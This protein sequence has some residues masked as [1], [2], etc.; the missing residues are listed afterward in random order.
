MTVRFGDISSGS[1]FSASSVGGNGSSFSFTWEHPVAWTQLRKYFEKTMGDEESKKLISI[2]ESNAKSL[3]D[4]LDVAYLKADGGSVFGE[5]NFTGNVNFTGYVN[6]PPPG[7]VVQWAGASTFTAPDGWLFADGSEWPI[8]QLTNL[9]NALTDN[10]TVFPYGANTNGSGG[11]GSTHFRLPN[12]AGRVPVGIDAGQ[13]EFDTMGETGG[14][15]THTLTE[16]QMPSHFHTQQGN[17]TTGSENVDHFHPGTTASNGTHDHSIDVQGMVTQSHAHSST[18]LDSVAGKPNPSTGS[19]VATRSPI[20]NDGSHTHVF[21]TNGRS[22]THEHD[23]TL[24]GNT[25]SKGS[26]NAHNNLQ[27]YIVLNYI[28]KH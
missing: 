1:P 20:D 23:F 21:N 3:E 19:S 22:N 26:G 12:L 17:L 6:V 2:L 16:A 4:F 24:T 15:K 10:G 18:T 8:A 27:P 9:Y 28:I 7:T 13:T 25:A 11:V 5:T 14:A